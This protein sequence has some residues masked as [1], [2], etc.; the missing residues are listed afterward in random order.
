MKRLKSIL[1]VILFSILYLQ[2]DLA[3]D[4]DA[5]ATA[6]E[7]IS[8]TVPSPPL[9]VHLRHQSMS[10]SLAEDNKAFISHYEKKL[11]DY[12][13]KRQFPNDEDIYALVAIISATSSEVSQKACKLARELIFGNC[14]EHKLIISLYEAIIFYSP[15]RSIRGQCLDEL[16]YYYIDCLQDEE[17]VMGTIDIK[18][19]RRM[20]T[21]QNNGVYRSSFEALRIY[22]SKRN[23]NYFKQRSKDA[24]TQIDSIQGNRAI[25]KNSQNLVKLQEKVIRYGRLQEFIDTCLK[26]LRNHKGI[27]LNTLHYIPG[28]LK[29]EQAPETRRELG[30]LSDFLVAWYSIQDGDFW[31]PLPEEE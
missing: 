9:P 6:V 17:L 11:D 20:A 31:V 21:H 30:L 4:V 26:Y 13:A 1:E 23:A 29:R 2:P 24:R 5:L 7:K 15:D 18:L 22:A 25:T 12:K 14:L 3:A 10:Q 28:Y 27:K 8:L 16:R 19:L